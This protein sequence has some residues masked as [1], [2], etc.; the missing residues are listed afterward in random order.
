MKKSIGKTVNIWLDIAKAGLIVLF[1]I[2]GSGRSTVKARVALGAM[3]WLLISQIVL[4]TP[5]SLFIRI[6]DL[7]IKIWTVE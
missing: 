6:I 7:S 5:V 2:I 4:L 1:I 3:I